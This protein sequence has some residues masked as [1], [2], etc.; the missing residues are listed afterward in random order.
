MTVGSKYPLSL[1][2]GKPILS[3]C[4]S[5][6]EKERLG[7]I[8]SWSSG[9]TPSKANIEYWGGTIP[10]MSAKTM[11]GTSFS[12]SNLCISEKGLKTGSKLANKGD[13]LPLVRGSMLWNKIP[14]GIAKKN[15]AFNQDVKCISPKQEKISS[16]F[17][18][19]WFSAHENMLLHMVTGTGIGAGKLDTNELTSLKIS[20][21]PLTEQQKIAQIL[22]TW[23]K[24][25]NTTESL[26]ANS[27]QQK[28]PL[29]QQLLTGKKRFAE[30]EG[31]WQ[32]VT[33]SDCFDH[34]GGTAL[35][36][37][38]N[39]E[40]LHHF[41]S[42]GNYAIDGKYVDKKQRITLNTKTSTKLLSKND[43]V[44]VLNDKTKTG[45][46]IGSTILID[47]DNKYIYNQRSE[48]LIPHDH[49]HPIFFWFL[50][51]SKD[52]RA[53]VFNR[54][55]GGTQIYV[56]FSGIKSIKLLLPCI[57]EQ[58]KIASALTAADQEIYTLQQKLTYLKQEK[59]AL[60]QQLLTGKRRVKVD[61]ETEAA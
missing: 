26:I 45:D 5:E 29:M 14:V 50:L 52:I 3:E 23:D 35:E 4:P 43:L 30:F 31:E 42:I 2:A 56:N 9:G 17:L 13:L 7:E 28:K 39:S 38:V 18:L 15:L 24:A 36:K 8:T 47:E 44:M 27:Q 19:F 48:R 34:I 61:N 40:A 32:E 60:M 20:L 46:I 1:K 37:H 51:N 33:L 12:H 41:I 16:R 25:I 58:Q 10:W 49:I 59:K 53:E 54:S 57:K 6:W 21:P 22:S 55:Q 11:R